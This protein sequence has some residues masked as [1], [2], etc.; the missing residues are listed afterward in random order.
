[1]LGTH[2]LWPGLDFIP[3]ELIPLGCHAFFRREGQDAQIKQLWHL[4]WP[5]RRCQGA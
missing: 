1:M 3:E 2:T 5:K 4:S